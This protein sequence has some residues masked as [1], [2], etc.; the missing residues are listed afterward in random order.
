[1]MNKHL[2]VKCLF[3]FAVLAAGCLDHSHRPP[4]DSVA[5]V[6]ARD[7]LAK[8]IV[9]SGGWQNW[10]SLDTIAYLKRTLLFD[11]LGN[12]ESDRKELH[13][14]RLQ[15]ELTMHISWKEG[16]DSH[17][18]FY[19]KEQVEKR[20]NGSP[21]SAD[22]EALRRT[23]SSALYVLFMPFKL[24]DPGVK[25][26]YKGIVTLP[27]GRRVHVIAANYEPGEH[28]E[29]YFDRKTC[30][31]VASM[32]DHG[33]YRALVTNDEFITL[34]GLRFNAFRTSHRVDQ[35]RKILYKRGEFYYDDFAVQ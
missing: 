2:S 9:R 7:V 20:L 18:I 25:L 26:T 23:A 13:R 16:E 19:R 4:L 35:N 11:S 34:G 22:T 1:M 31:F 21:V 12:L 15:P 5:D 33:D 32:V 14:Y 29:Y 30:D 17:E 10:K 3:L 24:L 28:W 6:K 8:A 27:D